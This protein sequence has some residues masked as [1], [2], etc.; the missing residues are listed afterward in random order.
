MLR[1]DAGAVATAISPILLLCF[2]F[3]PKTG[4]YDFAVYRALSTLAALTLVTLLGPV[5]PP[6]A[7]RR[8]SA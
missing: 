6:A 8:G 1:A 7:S 3:D 5:S 2:H 4:T